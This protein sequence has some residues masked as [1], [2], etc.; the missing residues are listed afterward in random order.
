MSRPDQRGIGNVKK[1]DL[2]LIWVYE[3]R[4]LYGIFEI[5]D[6]IFYD[7]TDIGWRGKWYYRFPFR[8]WDNYLRFIPDNRKT[9]LM[10]FISKEMT[11]L[12]DTSDFNQRYVNALLY[13]EGTK[14]LRF[15]VG[16]SVMCVPEAFFSRFGQ[17][18][19]VKPPIDFRQKIVSTKRL[20]EYVLELFLLQ[21][22]Q[23]LNELL[24]S[25]I[26]ELYN[27][28]FVY[29]NRFMDILVVHRDD[30]G[31]LCKATIV[32]LKSKSNQQGIQKGVEELLHYMYWISDKL[33]IRKDL[34]FGLLLSPSVE[35]A[36]VSTFQ[37]E[38]LKTSQIYGCNPEKIRWMS[39]KARDK[40][41]EFEPIV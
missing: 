8:L 24:G 27:Q 7:E 30:H 10:S 13:S 16:N 32:E 29:A 21:Y 15:F 38:V 18:R 3:D 9:K 31:K 17:L 39:Y 2:A 36:S 19:T 41:L 35:G 23:K 33:E 6:R 12:T 37:N 20:A 11:T 25:G 1:G 14:T 4:N 26:S 5:L 22:P 34:V 28:I 40:D